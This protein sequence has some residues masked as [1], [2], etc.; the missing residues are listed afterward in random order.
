MAI[1]LTIEFDH[2][3]STDEAAR[4]YERRIAEWIQHLIAVNCVFKSPDIHI[5]LADHPW[6]SLAPASST[7]LDGA[8]SS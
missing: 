3:G 8:P 6:Q 5:D 1:S 4:A 7:S 2:A